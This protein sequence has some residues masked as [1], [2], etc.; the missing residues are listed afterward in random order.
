MRAAWPGIL[1]PPSSSYR[2]AEVESRTSVVS[3]F[4]QREPSPG[5]PYLI[6]RKAI[7]DSDASAVTSRDFCLTRLDSLFR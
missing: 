7:G 4:A 2:I 6:A 3:R 5:E 1:E